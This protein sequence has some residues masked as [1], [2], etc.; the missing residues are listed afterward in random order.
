[1]NTFVFQRAYESTPKLAPTSVVLLFD[2]QGNLIVRDNEPFELPRLSD[3][4]SGLSLNSPFKVGTLSGEDCIVDDAP[5][6]LVQKYGWKIVGLRDLYVIA[7]GHALAM[8]GYSW[9]IVYFRRNHTYCPRCGSL[10]MSRETDWGRPCSNCDY[11]LYP[12]TNPAVL[13][14]VTDHDRILLVHK[15]GW[16]DRYSI[17]AGFVDPCESLEECVSRE[18]MEETGVII[19]NIAYVASQPWP[20]PHQLMM[21]FKAEYVSGEVEHHDIEIDDARWFTANDMPK[22]LPPNA[23]LSRMMIDSWVK[24]RI[25]S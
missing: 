18:V 12:R 3:I 20:F 24:S 16:G 19:Q 25:K 21:A 8:A 14:C 5:A 10:T 22:V 6:D 2:Q 9:Q 15:P 17:V 23:S 4:P 1:V 13:A 11:V 7:D